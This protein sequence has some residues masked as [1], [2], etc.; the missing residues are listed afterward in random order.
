M[1]A[2]LKCAAWVVLQV[3]QNIALKH[4]EAVDFPKTGKPPDKLVVQWKGGLPPE[5][6]ERS[7]DF[8]EKNYEPQYTSRRLNGQLFRLLVGGGGLRRTSLDGS[9]W[10]TTSS[11]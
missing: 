4:M 3:C 5:K 8:M 6:S 9:R 1:H 2:Q 7:P 11:R 10:W